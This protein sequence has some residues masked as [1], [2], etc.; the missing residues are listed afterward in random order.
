MEYPDAITIHNALPAS[1]VSRARTFVECL[2]AD[3]FD[4]YT[5][6]FEPKLMVKKEH[7]AL[8]PLADV[9]SI[10][11]SPEF[12]AFFSRAFGIA[13]LAPSSDYF[14]AVYVY[15]TGDYLQRHIDAAV[16]GEE[17]KTV[18]TNLYLSDCE[19]GELSIGR[20][21]VKSEANT[22]VAFANHDGSYH[23]VSKVRAGQRIMVTTGLCLPASQFPLNGVAGFTRNNEKA[24]FVPSHGEKWTA[25]DFKARDERASRGWAGGGMQ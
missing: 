1:L 5:H 20:R 25:E 21:V 14:L 13:G 16:H 3:S 4:V 10:L 6:R 24:W 9:V 8:S 2:P 11:R 23:E 17:R 22:L 7:Y 15:R 19:G 12:T 18:T